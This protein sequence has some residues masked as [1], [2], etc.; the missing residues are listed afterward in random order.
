MKRLC[1]ISGI[2]CIIALTISVLTAQPEKIIIDNIETFITKQRSSV[3]F[4]HGTHMEGELECTDCHHDYKDGKNILNEDELEE[5]NSTVKCAYCHG[6]K[7]EN[8]YNLREAFHKQCMGC[9][10]KLDKAGEKTG[11]RLCGECHPR[12]RSI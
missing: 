7:T 5:G 12:K 9:H 6:G 1:L 2:S 11:P 10:R 3:D 4:P 8:D